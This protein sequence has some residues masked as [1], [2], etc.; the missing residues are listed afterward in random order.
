VLINLR[1]LQRLQARRTT[2]QEA[3]PM[4]RT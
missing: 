4:P 2:V 3:A 1:A